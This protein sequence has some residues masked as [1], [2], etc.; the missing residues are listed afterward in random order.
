MSSLV[1]GAFGLTPG[2]CHCIVRQHHLE[3]FLIC[4]KALLFPPCR[5]LWWWSNPRRDGGWGGWWGGSWR[6]SRQ[7]TLS[8][9][10]P[11]LCCSK[12]FSLFG[13]IAQPDLRQGMLVEKSWG[14]LQIREVYLLRGLAG[15]QLPIN[16]MISVYIVWIPLMI[17]SAFK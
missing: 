10:V 15:C 14:N 11:L 5:Q 9:S 17:I 8:G 2:V 16:H 12:S 4:G 7:G 6:H 3:K 1:T 13:L